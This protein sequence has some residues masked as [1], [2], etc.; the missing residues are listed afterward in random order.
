MP[1]VSNGG[2]FSCEAQAVVNTATMIINS[3]WRIIKSPFRRVSEEKNPR[4][5]Y[6]GHAVL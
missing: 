3:N 2:L 6:S 1:S 4:F 5:V